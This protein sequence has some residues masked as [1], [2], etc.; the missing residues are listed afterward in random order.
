MCVTLLYD[1]LK[2]E[3][4]NDSTKIELIKKF[5]TVLSLDLLKTSEV[6]KELETKIKDLIEERNKYKQEKNYAKADEIRA[7]IESLG[8]TIKDTREGVEIIWN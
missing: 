2:D 3:R 4:L 6:D 8:V 1:L 7:Q 5:D